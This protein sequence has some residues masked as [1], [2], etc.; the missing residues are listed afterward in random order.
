MSSFIEHAC[1]QLTHFF[2]LSFQLRKTGPGVQA[3]GSPGL[4]RGLPQRQH[5]AGGRQEVSKW[6]EQKEGEGRGQ[7][8]AAH[9]CLFPLQVYVI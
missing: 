1:E 3:R 5:L 2:S 4:V 9:S 6:E 8:S 7:A